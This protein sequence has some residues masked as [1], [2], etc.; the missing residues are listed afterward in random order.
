MRERTITVLTE[1]YNLD[2]RERIGAIKIARLNREAIAACIDACRQRG[3]P[4][5]AQ[6]VYRTMKGL[7]AFAIKRDLIVADVMRGIDPPRPYRPGPVVSASDAEIKALLRVID[8]SQLHLS[9]RLLT[10]FLLLTGARIGEGRLALWTEIDTGKKLWIIPAERSKSNREH[11][12]HLSTQSLQILERAAILRDDG[13]KTAFNRPEG[14]QFIFPGSASRKG[15]PLEK[16]AVARAL[17]RL[18]DRI[19]KKLTPHDLRRTL[20]TTMARIGIAPHVAE[21][22]LGHLEREVLRR[23]YDG[24]DYAAEMREA[25]DRVGAHVA[26]FKAGG[27]EVIPITSARAA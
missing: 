18:T 5:A 26:A 2:C 27:A 12:V 4:G 1:N 13:S 25:W 15:G 21:L 3:A 10:E 19:G 24:H 20:R 8:D 16:M 22:C 9:S 23:V 17:A 11:R 6:Q 14:A 7:L